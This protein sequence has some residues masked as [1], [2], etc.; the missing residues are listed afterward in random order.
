MKRIFAI[1]MGAALIVGMTLGTLSLRA[2]VR[3]RVCHLEGHQ[4]GRAHVIEISDS[5]VAAH[6]NHGDSLQAAAGLGVGDT[7]VPGSAG[8]GS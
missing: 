1:A 8:S 3:V 7:C 6:L 4:S 2:A 5:A